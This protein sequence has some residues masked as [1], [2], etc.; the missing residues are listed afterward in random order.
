MLMKCAVCGTD[1]EII[2]HQF[3]KGTREKPEKVWSVY[4]PLYYQSNKENTACIEGYCSCLCSVKKH[5]LDRVN[6]NNIGLE[7]A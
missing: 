1:A 5:E 6:S 4:A 3:H 2:E 7:N